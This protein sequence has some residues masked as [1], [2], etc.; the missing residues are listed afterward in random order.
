MFPFLPPRYIEDNG[1]EMPSDQSLKPTAGGR[2]F[3][4]APAK[5]TGSHIC[6]PVKKV[7]TLRSIPERAVGVH[8]LPFIRRPTPPW[9]SQ[10]PTRKK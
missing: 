6:R 4:E 5:R 10:S 3:A 8:R 7:G 2:V 9:F 1:M